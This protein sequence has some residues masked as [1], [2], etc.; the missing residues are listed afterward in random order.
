MEL[1]KILSTPESE[2][3]RTILPNGEVRTVPLADGPLIGDAADHS[4]PEQ[5][6][7]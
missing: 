3:Q 1:E 2:L 4:P 6:I 7:L 5:E